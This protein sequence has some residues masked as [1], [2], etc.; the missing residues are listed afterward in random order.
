[1]LYQHPYCDGTAKKG[2]RQCPQAEADAVKSER[3]HMVHA[4]ALGNKGKAPDG[5]RDE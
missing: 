1:M 2:Q 3:P 5:G 4:Y